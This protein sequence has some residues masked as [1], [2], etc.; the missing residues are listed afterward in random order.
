MNEEL[1]ES[2]RSVLSDKPEYAAL[3][4]DMSA[5]EIA[6][7]LESVPIEDRLVL[8]SKIETSKRLAILICL[9]HS[10][11]DSLIDEMS[12]D[13]LDLIFD[14]ISADQL[15]ELAE[16]LPERLIQRA[17]RL[18]DDQQKEYF[19]QAQEFSDVQIGHWVNQNLLMLSDRSK[20][21]DS[22]R[23]VRREVPK[24]TSAI[25]LINKDGAY[26]GAVP[27]YKLLGISELTKLSE[28]LFD[29]YPILNAED[30][31]IESSRR[32]INSGYSSLPVIDAS[33]KLVGRLDVGTAN[34]I[35]EQDYESAIMA[36][37]GLDE[38]EDLFSPVSKSIKGRSTWLGINLLTALL[39][40][41]FIGLFEATLETVVAL[42]VLMPVVASMGGIAGSQTLALIIR[43]LALGQV[44]ESNSKALLHKELK[45]GAVNGCLWST[46][47]A[48]VA[49]LWFENVM[50]G[51]V[52]A[53]A[54]LVNIIIAAVAGIIVPIALKKLKF[55]PA[56][57]GAVILTTI[58][59]IVGFVVF[60][61]LGSLLLT[62]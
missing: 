19:Q 9:R 1:K 46:V 59:D 62:A 41:W 54:I 31:I 34:E 48:I 4:E 53:L 56:L 49:S 43:G 11:R 6:L 18:M 37:A 42:A 7:L 17:L 22:L 8:W 50:I 24:Y 26:Q 27:L 28:L 57:S 13:D 21:R 29:E 36:K 45:V 14:D 30:G 5:D 61:G 20:V 33:N 44:N 47:I 35:I 38:Q 2:V 10:P 40:S 12:F 15:I 51:I 3:I 16:T 25:F 55:D 60:L 39:A 32:I 52:I 23:L 58:T